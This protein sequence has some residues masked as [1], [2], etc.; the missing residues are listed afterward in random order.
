MAQDGDLDILFVE[1]WSGPE[2][3][4]EPADKQESDRTD[5]L[6]DLGRRAAALLRG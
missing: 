3:V 4:E 1:R 6:G 2:Q 5:H